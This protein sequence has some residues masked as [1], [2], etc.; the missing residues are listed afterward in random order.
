MQ[1]VK[2][3]AGIPY[4]VPRIA[5]SASDRPTLVYR[6]P[7]KVSVRPALPRGTY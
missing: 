5:D 2:S 1:K 6:A 7:Q 3:V 4:V